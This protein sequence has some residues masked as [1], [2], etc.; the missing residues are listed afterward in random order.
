MVKHPPQCRRP[1]FNPWVRKI[2]WRR[3][4]QLT[5]VSLPGEFHGQ[6]SLVDYSPWGSQSDTTEHPTHT[7]DIEVSGLPHKNLGVDTAQPSSFFLDECAFSG[8]TGSLSLWGFLQRQQAGALPS[9]SVQASR[10]AAFSG[11]W[12]WPL[13]HGRCCSIACEIFPDHGS[14]PC[15]LHWQA[16]S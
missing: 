2:H 4:W 7:W 8:C 10:G 1:G 6:R 16:D 11:C 15:P 12:A 5:P 13:E 9:C 14:N 3:K